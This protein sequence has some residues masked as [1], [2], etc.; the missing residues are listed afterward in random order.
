MWKHWAP[1]QDGEDKILSE[2]SELVLHGVG[3]GVRESLSGDGAV[4]SALAGVSPGCCTHA[5][6]RALYC[7]PDANITLYVN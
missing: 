7:T 4:R 5:L 1:E 3:P 6:R 2:G